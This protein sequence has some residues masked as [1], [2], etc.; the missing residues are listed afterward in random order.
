M[1]PQELKGTGAVPFLEY[2]YKIKEE[3]TK[4]DLQGNTKAINNALFKIY[5]GMRFYSLPFD[6]S[7]LVNP[8]PYPN[9]TT[10]NFDSEGKCTNPEYINWQ[11]AED[12][13]IFEGWG[14]KEDGLY[15][16]GYAMPFDIRCV[17]VNPK[18]VVMIYNNLS[19]RIINI[20]N[21][22]NLLLSKGINLTFKK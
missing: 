2:C 5:E 18:I 9:L 20:D 15:L 22:I 19:T 8:I 13:V 21:F 16:K 11:Q 1:I 4:E 3:H 14:L 12:K 6:V 17:K 10:I 7:M